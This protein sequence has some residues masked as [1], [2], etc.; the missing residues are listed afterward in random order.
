MFD[1][2]SGKWPFINFQLYDS[3]GFT[4]LLYKRT[5]RIVEI[6]NEHRNK[7]SFLEKVKVKKVLQYLKTKI[8]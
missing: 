7:Q 6:G 4:F 8:D 2:V 5:T 1:Y 3:L